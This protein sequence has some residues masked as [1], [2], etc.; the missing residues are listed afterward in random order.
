MV[1]AL[2]GLLSAVP[3]FMALEARSVIGIVV[4]AVLL[5]KIA[6]DMVVSVQQP[7]FFTPF[8]AT[9][10]VWIDGTWHAVAVYL[11]GGCLLSLV[12][13]GR[14]KMSAGTQPEASRT[15]VSAA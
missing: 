7:L 9:A 14:M 4:F 5:A 11:A 2:A 1:G 12:V 15:A 10:L 8:N 6:H 13:A 3:F